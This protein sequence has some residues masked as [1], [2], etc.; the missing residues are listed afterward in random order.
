MTNI[1]SGPET[2]ITTWEY[3]AVRLQT[4]PKPRRQEHRALPPSKIPSG[5]YRVW[6][7]GPDYVYGVGNPQL[8]HPAVKE[9]ITTGRM[10]P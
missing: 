4:A 1:G 3:G 6:E 10:P 7:S 9:S 5:R 2:S 8:T